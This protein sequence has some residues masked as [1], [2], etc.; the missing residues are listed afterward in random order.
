MGVVGDQQLQHLH[1]ARPGRPQK[2][3]EGIF[4]SS[5]QIHKA[6]RL[7]DLLQDFHTP[8]RRFGL[9]IT[10]VQR[11]AYAAQHFERALEIPV[12]RLE[13]GRP[14][15]PVEGVDVCASFVDE[16]S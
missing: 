16:K 14:E 9:V 2:Q 5:L 4:I 6:I 12:A 7:Q 13:Y 11:S 10:C 1:M 8:H 3:R 15:P